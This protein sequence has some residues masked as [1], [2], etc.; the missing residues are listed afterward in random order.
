M[1]LLHLRRLLAAAIVAAAL[2]AGLVAGCTDDPEA[3][4]YDNPFDPGNPGAADPFGLTAELAGDVVLLRWTQLEGY[5]ITSYEVQTSTDLL[6]YST[7]GDTAA[8]TGAMNYTVRQVTPTATNYFRVKAVGE[9]GAAPR[10]SHVVPAQLSIGPLLSVA[11]PV[12][13]LSR[14]IELQA[15]VTFGDSVEL[16]REAT[17]AAPIYAAVEDS[18]AV[19]ADLDLGATADPDTVFTLYARAFRNL[20]GGPS[21]S[22]ISSRALTIGLAPAIALVGGG[23]AIAAPLVDVAVADSA[24]GIARIRLAASAEDL[25]DAPWQDAAPVLFD[26]PVRDT[27]EPQTLHAQFETAFGY[28][29]ADELPLQADDLAAADFQLDLPGS[30]ISATGELTLLHDAVA[31]EMRV[32]ADPG[33]AGAPWV[34]YADTSQLVLDVD[35]GLYLVHVQYRNHWFLSP[36]RSDYV[37]L[38]GAE[39]DVQFQNPVQDQVVRGGSVIEVA[40]TASTFDA[41]Y[42]ITGVRV[43]LG[44][45]WTEAAGTTNWEATWEVPRLGED[46]AWSLG[47]EVTALGPDEDERTGVAWISVTISQLAVAIAAPLPG[48]ELPR[49]QEAVV[50]GTAS[51]FLAG[52][53]LDSVVVIAHEDTLR[54]AAPLAEWSVT[55]PVPDGPI[56]PLP[57]RIVAR[58][59]AGGETV[60]DTLAVTLVEAP[61]EE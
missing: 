23:S 30:R 59:F 1:T 29:V 11:G 21:Y 4:R 43:H 3:P 50:S 55:W 8:G 24:A 61:P 41:N 53:A 35:P 51:P 37:I 6:N 22:Q 19:F 47:A 12:P 52:A 54:A 33:F 27:V 25:P 42:E 18:V 16:A 32:S 39:L 28:T 49:G 48:A 14:R 58:A 31:T 2:A 57:V 9:G 17:F 44:E 7:V 15:R 56:S 13:V 46:T 38:S 45:E 36:I 40:G 26:V 34:A 60:A 10:M 5:G 20:G